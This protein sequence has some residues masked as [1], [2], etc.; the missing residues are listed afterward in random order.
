MDVVKGTQQKR[1]GTYIETKNIWNEHSSETSF[2]DEQGTLCYLRVAA[3]RRQNLNDGTEYRE[4]HLFFDDRV[5]PFAEYNSR[6]EWKICLFD[7]NEMM[8]QNEWTRWT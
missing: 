8:I 3:L 7:V 5:V 1:N 6:F 4:M 2:L